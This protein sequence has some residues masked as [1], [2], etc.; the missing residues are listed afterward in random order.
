[1]GAGGSSFSVFNSGLTG[2]QLVKNSKEINEMSNALFQF[3]YSNSREKDILDIANNPEKYVIALSDLITTQFTVLGY[4][5]RTGRMGEIYFRKHDD[6]EPPLPSEQ[7]VDVADQKD[8]RILSEIRNIGLSRK[9][10]KDFEEKKITRRRRQKGYAK[11]K[12]N[13]EIIAFYFVRLFQILG[14][15]LLVVKDINIPEYDPRD[16]K[17]LSRT[18]K[19][20]SS[21]RDYAQQM[22]PEHYTMQSFKPPNLPINHERLEMLEARERDRMS[23]MNKSVGTAP[24]ENPGPQVGGGNFNTNKPLGP[25]EFLRYY[26]RIPNSNDNE[27]YKQNHINTR[28]EPDKTF[29][30][31]KA[32]LLVFRFTAPTNPTRIDGNHANGGLQELGIPATDGSN[33]Y[34]VKFIKVSIKSITYETE[35]NSSTSSLNG[36][37]TP[38]SRAGRKEEIYPTSVTIKFSEISGQGGNTVTFQRAQFNPSSSMSNGL[39]Y[40]ISAT[41]PSQLLEFLKSTDGLNPKKNFEEILEKIT[42]HFLKQKN[43]SISFLKLKSIETIID[44]KDISSGSRVIIPESKNKSIR[45]IV[46]VLNNTSQSYQPH[47]ISRALQLLDP[48][49]INNFSSGTAISNI[50]KYSVGKSTNPV[51]MSEY[52]STRS[53]GQ[54]YGKINPVDYENSMEILKAFVQKDSQGDPVNLSGV[55][56]IPGE[57]ES[58]LNAITRLTKAFNIVYNKDMHKGFTDVTIGKSKECGNKNDEIQVQRGDPIF[59]EMK[60]H[61]QNLLAYHFNQIVEI[62]KFLKKIFNISRRADGSWKVEGPKTELL[63]AGFGILD[64]LTNQ[65]RELLVKYYT[66][67]EDIYQKGVK[68]WETGEIKKRG[69]SAGPA[70]GSSGPAPGSSGPAPG[71]APG[72]APGAGSSGPT[73]GPAPGPAPGPALGPAPAPGPAPSAGKQPT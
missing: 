50:C 54:L 43:P 4:K 29:L 10:K 56:K 71:A 44:D 7:E 69:P 30:F 33:Q 9:Y 19:D 63:F 42:Q 11:H 24:E 64:E 38:A 49:S 18:D 31:D 17:I 2:E 45:D 26:L 14:A 66:G 40:I 51:K 22:Y 6:L 62:S 57:S 73:A 32:K 61:S 13:S 58:L 25:F 3:M 59:N 37:T 55:S 46:N 16:G 1:M 12:Q 60:V 23:K 65:A 15:L 48:A 27:L 36:Y 21:Y 53:L 41:E 28:L 52:I 20:N 70:A 39:E 35:Q 5:T 72:P 34:E 8:L 47:C 68:A 67:C